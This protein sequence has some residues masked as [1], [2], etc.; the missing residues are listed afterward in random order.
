MFAEESGM[1]KK[2]FIDS[3]KVGSPCG[4]DWEMMSG[5]ERVRFC[6]H[7]SKHVNNLSEMTRKQASRFV[8]ASGGDICIRYIVNP[9]TKQ[10]LFANQL[11]QIKRR[12][13]GIAAGAVAASM[14]LSTATY[15][16]GGMAP[17][18][19]DKA[20]VRAEGKSCDDPAD[21]KSKSATAHKIT[22][23]VVDPNGAVIPNASITLFSS[24]GTLTT[25]S[26]SDGTYRFEN[27][28]PGTYRIETSSPG[29]RNNLREVVL[30]RQD[31][32]I[33]NSAL[34]IVGVNEVVE[35]KL[36]VEV[37]TVTVG[38]AMVVVE[39]TSELSRAIA[40]DDVE[41]VRELLVKGAN[42]NAKEA[43]YSK[44]TPLF[45][46]VEQGNVEIVRLLLEFGA[47]VNARDNEKQ[48]PLMRLDDDA[49]PELVELLLQYRAKVD[50]VDNDGNTALIIVAESVNPEVLEALIDGGADVNAS[51]KEGKTPLMSA[52]DSDN[53]E[54]VR[55][56][57]VAGA[58][59]TAKDDEGDDAWEYANDKRIKALL[60]SYGAT[61]RVEP[62]D[63]D[64]P[65][66]TQNAE[67]PE[68]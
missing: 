60:I 46:A 21:N 5:N 62:P 33:A 49:T 23:T 9:V 45:V 15:A 6:T 26:D 22:G 51:N 39:Y 13:P 20:V 40:D 34:E 61:P 64:T 63:E 68:E 3:V 42:P 41:L 31:E 25:S 53:I 58:S 47:K 16:Q 2:S 50:A 54:S 43:S 29:F 59:A 36:D 14:S 7:C 18:T 11:L 30:G 12:A 67:K 66:D 57:L 38:G 65:D 17:V 35:V 55:T 19:V 28:L 27:L 24:E 52:A 32:V 4:E 44:I 48:T 8:R 37:Q 1:S 56:L 10:P